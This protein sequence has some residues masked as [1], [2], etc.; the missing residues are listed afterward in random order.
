MPS[1]GERSKLMHSRPRDA[2]LALCSTTL[3]EVTCRPSARTFGY[4]PITRAS[5]ACGGSSSMSERSPTLRA[6]I[7]FQMP[8]TRSRRM[9][10]TATS[11]SGASRA[12]IAS[13]TGRCGSSQLGT[14]DLTGMAGRYVRSGRFVNLAEG[15][16]TSSGSD[17]PT[18][19]PPGDAFRAYASSGG[20][21]GG[22]SATSLSMFS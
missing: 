20:T 18:S 2:P 17:G 15:G 19:R 16:A 13:Q 6:E 12:T 9:S 10:C 1:S 21:G 4:G 14:G 11:A 7:G 5:S 3:T 22:N 8:T